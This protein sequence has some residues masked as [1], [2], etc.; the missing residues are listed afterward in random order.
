MTVT[1]LEYIVA[2]GECK[3]FANAA[4]KCHITQ[5]TL[6]MQIKKL[7]E[8]LNVLL[9]DRSKKPVRPTEIGNQIIE[10]AR[11]SL[12]EI[13]SIHSIIES[14]EKEEGELRI[15]IIPTLSPYLLPLFAIEFGQKFPNTLITINEMLSEEIAFN[16]YNNNLDLGILVTPFDTPGLQKSTL[17]YEPFIAYLAADHPLSNQSKIDIYDL[18]LKDIWLLKEGHC[19]RNQAISICSESSFLENNNNVRFEGASLETLR[20]IVEKQYGY[21]LLPELATLGFTEEQAKMVKEFKDPKPTREVSLIM[22]RR[23]MKRKLI[24]ALKLTIIENIPEQF[25]AIKSKNIVPW[26]EK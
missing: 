2:V 10:Q 4:K 15:G 3:S 16:L 26:Q 11:I 17:F 25:S 12:G 18:D 9:F 20:R 24:E 23:F 6:S 8:E 14:R 13:R 5:P 7:E 1:Q 22:P 19:F 21:T